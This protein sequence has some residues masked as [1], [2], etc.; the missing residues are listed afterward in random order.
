MKRI[1]LLISVITSLTYSSPAIYGGRGLY[2]TYDAITEELGLLQA[3]FYATVSRNASEFT[4]NFIV[5]NLSY[6]PGRF[7]EIFFATAQN[8]QARITFP[9][10][11]NS[12]F[13]SQLTSRLVGGKLAFPYIKVLK[14]GA[15]AKYFWNHNGSQNNDPG[16]HWDGLLNLR[17]KELLSGL[18]DLLVNYGES[19]NYRYFRGALEIIGEKGIIFAEANT[20][21]AKSATNLYSELKDNLV[22]VP[23][24]K[25]NLTAHAYFSLG[26]Q[27]T[28]LTQ[29]LNYQIITGL[30]LGGTFFR[31]ATIKRALLVG[32]VYDIYTNRRLAATVRIL[33]L[34]KLSPV[35]TQELTGMFKFSDIPIG[36]HTIMITAP[37]YE[38]LATPITIEANKIN[39]YDFKLKPLV[40]LG[41]ISGTI[42][43]FTTNQP[44][45]ATVIVNS[46]EYQSD[47]VTGAFRI[48]SVPQGVVTIEVKRP[49]YYPKRQTIIVD[50]NKVNQIDFSLVKSQA[51]GILTGTVTDKITGKPIQAKI[52]FVNSELPV[53]YTDSLTGIFYSEV[54]VSHYQMIVSADGYIAQILNVVIDKN[55]TT[56]LQIK[57]IPKENKAIFTGKVS[58]EKTQKALYAKI[59]FRDVLLDTIYADSLSGVFFAEVPAGEYNI[60]V[61]ATGYEPLQTT[62]SLS[63]AEPKEYNFALKPEE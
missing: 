27:L 39:T 59:V 8:W 7:L 62:V 61:Q 49:G 25:L 47:S 4:G 1:I 11:T 23:G 50:G 36:I 57:L 12:H 42:Y 10:I 18:P 44:L 21:C 16:L 31:P 60:E 28:N 41:I 33:D 35:K 29:N 63:Q 32:N 58:C 17:F 55:R 46:R 24:I 13:T 52:S 40:V 48:D 30:N 51:N 34:P 38:T 22:L 20:K 56:D 53:L 14:F 45:E 19:H 43:D 6:T 9:N 37:G 15:L 5:P 26:V 2:F 54:P 3:S